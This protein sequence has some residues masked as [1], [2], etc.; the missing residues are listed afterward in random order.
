MSNPLAFIHPT[1]ISKSFFGNTAD[2]SLSPDTPITSIDQK[3]SILEFTESEQKFLNAIERNSFLSTVHNTSSYILHAHHVLHKV[4]RKEG[5]KFSPNSP[6][7]RH[8]LAVAFR[9]F[10]SRIDLNALTNNDR[11]LCLL[12]HEEHRKLELEHKFP[13]FT[14]FVDKRA[15]HGMKGFQ[16]LNKFVHK[17]FCIEAIGQLLGIVANDYSLGEEDFNRIFPDDSFKFEEIPTLLTSEIKLTQPLQQKLTNRYLKSME[18]RVSDFSENGEKSIASHNKVLENVCDFVEYLNNPDVPINVAQTDTFNKLIERAESAIP[19]ERILEKELQDA[20][21]AKKTNE[22]QKYNQKYLEDA[23]KVGREIGKAIHTWI[24]HSDREKKHLSTT[25]KAYKEFSACMEA[26]CLDDKIEEFCYKSRPEIQNLIT[27][28]LINNHEKV[29]DRKILIA[30]EYARDVSAAKEGIK[31]CHQNFNELGKHKEGLQQLGN[32]L[33]EHQKKVDK[34]HLKRSRLFKIGKA[35]CDG[36]AIAG[37][38]ASGFVSPASGIASTI[39][40]IA[41]MTSGSEANELEN[42][43]SDFAKTTIHILDERNESRWEKSKKRY[44]RGLNN[45]LEGAQALHDGREFA[46]EHLF[47]WLQHRQQQR[48]FLVMHPQEFH[49]ITYQRYLLEELADEKQ[50]I[51]EIQR[52]QKECTATIVQNNDSL[53]LLSNKEQ[54]LKLKLKSHD[55]SKRSKKYGSILLQLGNVR[56]E[57]SKKSSENSLLQIEGD[58]LQSRFR[59]E[60]SMHEAIEGRLNDIQIEDSLPEHQRSDA[61]KLPLNLRIAS[62]DEHLQNLQIELNKRQQISLGKYNELNEKFNQELVYNAQLKQEQIYTSIKEQSPTKICQDLPSH[63]LSSVQRQNTLESLNSY[64]ATNCQALLLQEADAKVKF[65]NAKK[66]LGTQLNTCSDYE[67]KKSQAETNL[68]QTKEQIKNLLPNRNIKCKIKSGSKSNVILNLQ[69]FSHPAWEKGIEKY[70][71][72]FEKSEKINLEKALQL[73]A[74]LPSLQSHLTTMIQNKMNN[75]A[76]YRNVSLH[77]ENSEKDYRLKQDLRIAKEAQIAGQKQSQNGEKQL[78][79]TLWQIL[80]E[81]P[82]QER[83]SFSEVYIS[84]LKKS[85]NAP[86]KQFARAEQI[87]CHKIQQQ[88]YRQLWDG[89]A[90][91]QRIHLFQIHET[92][93]KK[94]LEEYNQILICNRKEAL[95]TQENLDENLIQNLKREEQEIL[96]QKSNEKDNLFSLRIGHNF[97]QNLLEMRAITGESSDPELRAIHAQHIEHLNK[98]GQHQALRRWTELSHSL[99]LLLGQISALWDREWHHK[100]SIIPQFITQTLNF[101][102][103]LTYLWKAGGA[104]A[105][106]SKVAIN[107]GKIDEHFISQAITLP[108]SLN[109]AAHAA[110]FFLSLPFASRVGGYYIPALTAMRSFVVLCNLFQSIKTGP[111]A[112]LQEQFSEFSKEQT[113]VQEYYHL[114]IKEQLK[115]NLGL[116][117]EVDQNLLELK[118]QMKE[119]FSRVEL[120]IQESQHSIEKKIVSQQRRHQT[121]ISVKHCIDVKNKCEALAQ[122]LGLWSLSDTDFWQDNNLKEIDLKNTLETIQFY[123]KLSLSTNNNGFD[124]G[125]L[126]D[127]LDIAA[128]PKFY[129]GWLGSHMGQQSVTDLN[130]HLPSPAI[131]ITTT[132]SFI[133][134]YKKIKV[135]SN[136]SPAIQELMVNQAK[137]LQQDVKSLLSLIAQRNHQLIRAAQALDDANSLLI[138]K[139]EKAELKRNQ[140]IL[141][142]SKQAINSSRDRMKALVQNPSFFVQRFAITRNIIHFLNSDLP[143]TVDLMKDLLHPKIRSLKEE[144]EGN[145]LGTVVVA[146]AVIPFMAVV[147]PCFAIISPLIYLGNMLKKTEFNSETPHPYDIDGRFG[148]AKM[149]D[150]LQ[151]VTLFAL[152]QLQARPIPKNELFIPNAEHTRESLNLLVKGGLENCPRESSDLKLLELSL[153]GSKFHAADL[154]IDQDEYWTNF[155]IKHEFNSS[156][157]KSS[158]L[159][160]SRVTLFFD[161]QLT[162]S[163]HF[164]ERSWVQVE[165]LSAIERIGKKSL[166]NLQDYKNR[167]AEI[168]T[169]YQNFLANELINPGMNESNFGQWLGDYQLIPPSQEGFPIA[170][171][172]KFMKMID[173]ILEQELVDRHLIGHPTLLPFYEW[174]HFELL[175]LYSLELIM[176]TDESKAENCH[177]F[178]LFSIEKDAVEAL[179]GRLE[180]CENHQQILLDSAILIYVMYCEFWK[181]GMPSDNSYKLA[182]GKAVLSSD[183]PFEGFYK[184]LEIKGAKYAHETLTTLQKSFAREWEE[185]GEELCDRARKEASISDSQFLNNPLF[186]EYRHQYYLAASLSKLKNSIETKKANQHHQQFEDISQYESTTIRAMFADNGLPWPETFEISKE[187]NKT[188]QIESLKKELD[189]LPFSKI[190]NSLADLYFELLP[191]TKEKEI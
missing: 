12:L 171:P 146:T 144:F 73:I 15:I 56:S 134:L 61:N 155:N 111:I 74:S 63:L 9:Y 143:I 178:T 106:D 68:N 18:N 38:I 23:F 19:S 129:T 42:V 94:R 159:V 95:E 28:K 7:H 41:K 163:A 169:G 87:I 20:E 157:V 188:A 158:P 37:R 90:P 64:E 122:K 5:K 132:N 184:I 24:Q 182:S 57:I 119:N 177:R 67:T 186:A 21:T 45:L 124:I 43:G 149:T 75:D 39:G 1:F 185:R 142:I 152:A 25:Q 104:L 53:N 62:S 147:L 92:A 82:P 125:K 148:A 78:Q 93:S 127:D 96:A 164:T 116:L 34:F 120:K 29:L 66:S 98:I 55:L 105:K 32:L 80:V 176:K 112:T 58:R 59:G 72:K 139:L 30:Q 170:L 70:S 103:G 16:K 175:D 113:K 162:R 167:G 121:E 14:E 140:A 165:D 33:K 150:K 81:M 117:Q 179:K 11:A 160:E 118:Q 76:E 109:N 40:T 166:K 2:Q 183:E 84:H 138:Q 168:A 47:P 17:G 48:E 102:A 100:A 154:T 22:T 101:S 35:I 49:S 153:E 172:K 50:F 141:E 115:N 128:H 36:I 3:A 27:N 174:H 83:I 44:T 52:R 151:Q 69:D 180:T 51:E 71:K 133:K 65:E 173:R 156:V 86:N 191:I 10:N 77:V 130:R 123:N 131:L 189:L 145:P 88:A 136:G 31:N 126:V 6:T 26:L 135:S 79:K 187:L 13:P 54:K 4:L 60:T 110:S 89:V 85:E 114:Q 91:D 46:Q 181:L 8:Q 97:D 137:R 99:E 108:L 190:A 107:L 161:K